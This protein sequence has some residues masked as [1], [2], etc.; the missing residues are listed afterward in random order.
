MTTKQ[1]IAVV[2]GGTGGL[3]EGRVQTA[4]RRQLFRCGHVFTRNLQVAAWLET[5]QILGESLHGGRG[6]RF[7]F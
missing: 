2:T 4:G 6:R 1:R 3:G 5:Q 7:A